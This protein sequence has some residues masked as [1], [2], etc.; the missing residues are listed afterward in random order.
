[1]Q[2]M[3]RHL[4]FPKDTCAAAPAK[5]KPQDL[6]W[7]EG[8]G[9]NSHPLGGYGPL[10]G[11]QRDL[12]TAC[13]GVESEVWE[14]KGTLLPTSP[15]T[16]LSY[17]ACRSSP[18]PQ[19]AS[20]KHVTDV[21]HPPQHRPIVPET[22]AQVPSMTHVLRAP[23]VQ[24][25][26][27]ATCNIQPPTAGTACPANWEPSTFSHCHHTTSVILLVSYLRHRNTPAGRGHLQGFTPCSKFLILD[28]S[29]S[30]HLFLAE[31]R[32][33][34]LPPHRSCSTRALL[35]SRKHVFA[36]SWGGTWPGGPQACCDSGTAAR[37]HPA[38]W[39]APQ[40]SHLSHPGT[41]PAPR[42]PQK[43]APS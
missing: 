6:P 18:C 17:K 30:S 35:F 43:P 26:T 39:D 10:P 33:I 41:L 29:L 11:P 19:S 31:P 1:M 5:H 36:S 34:L 3:G 24:P 16:M 42:E 28:T 21:S 14:V 8:A 20:P 38:G 9:D 4:H 25:K 40:R 15:N 2:C 7:E 32:T 23:P 12:L 37:G 27:G 13:F 22:Q